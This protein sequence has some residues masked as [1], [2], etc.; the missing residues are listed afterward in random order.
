MI[1]Y[2]KNTAREVAQR[3]GEH[4]TIEETLEIIR[5]RLAFMG[6]DD[7][8]WDAYVALNMAWS[9]TIGEGRD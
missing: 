8:I 5:P 1:H 3:Y 4:Y 6:D 2:D 7:T 9:L